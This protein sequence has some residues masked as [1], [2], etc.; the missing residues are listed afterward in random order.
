MISETFGRR[1][2][3][4]LI[5]GFA[6]LASLVIIACG[7][8]TTAPEPV[9]EPAAPAVSAP[10]PATEAASA[11][12]P[13]AS[14]ADTSAGAT[15]SMTEAPTVAPTHTP[16]P[17]VQPTP[18]PTA[19][20]V[21]ASRDDVVIVIN[22]EPSIPD[23]WLSTTLYPNQVIHNVVQPISFFGPDFTDTATAGFTGFEQVEPNTWRLS[24]REGVKFHNGEDW[25][26]EAAAYTINQL[27][28]NVEYQP[29]S[30][31]RDAH[32]DIIDDYTVDFVCE[33]ACPVLPRFGQ[34]HIFVAPGYHQ[35]ATQEERDASGKVIGWGPYE[36][37]EW[38]RGEYITL[39]AYDGYVEPQPVNFMTQ[40]PTITDVQYVWREEETVRTAMIQTGE[41]DLSWAVSID[42]AE[43]INN[44]ENGK[45][46]KVVSGEVYTINVDTIWHPELSKLEV[47]QALTHAINC[48]ELALAFF[49]PESRCSSG[50]NGIPGTLGV[51][52]DNSRP[53]Y[54]YNP[55]R[56]RELLIQADYNPDNEIE[57]WTRSGRYAKDVEIT[58]SL[59]TFWQEV[60]L[61]VE[62]QVVEGSVWRDRHLTGP[63]E[64]YKA[65]VEAG[66][67]SATAA[68]AVR[69]AAPPRTGASPGLVF[70]APGGEYF[71]FGRQINF[72]MS[73]E[74]N[75]SKNCNA[76]WHALGK[77]ALA[78]SGEERRE[79]MTEA[80]GVFTENLLQL[81]MMEIVSVWGVNKD[82]EFVNMPGGRRILI[83]TMTWS[84]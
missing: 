81:P 17:T 18:R 77:R 3:G 61:N 51:N 13:A 83:N 84:K 19:A 27:G 73:C 29:Y 75:R 40:A 72:Y 8:A 48:E 55:E 45:T 54:P 16:V 59:I 6:V 80:Y 58:E 47:R 79:L 35:S 21:V 15:E 41:A 53:I 31:V 28:S 49:G 71:D 11:A 9:A 63:A 65:E 1:R 10:E 37:G 25:N 66:A 70:F 46:V 52:E 7:G 4:R 24:L 68:A 38:V 23:P 69:D 44:S 42:Q 2:W 60:G 76:E 67:D 20:E 57:F 62:A 22:E 64:T 34:F 50:P 43:A 39:T 74:A 26:A 56:A 36:W 30:Q 82:L 5:L 32:A 78:S 12:A 14:P 33:S